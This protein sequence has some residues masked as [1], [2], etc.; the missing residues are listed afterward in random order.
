V[1]TFDVKVHGT[2]TWTINSQIGSQQRSNGDRPCF[3]SVQFKGASDT[4]DA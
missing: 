2:N 4:V 3:I 1:F